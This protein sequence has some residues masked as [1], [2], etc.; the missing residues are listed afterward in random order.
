MWQEHVAILVTAPQCRPAGLRAIGRYHWL[1][2]PGVCEQRQRKTLP[3][4]L[5]GTLIRMLEAKRT[6]SVPWTEIRPFTF[7]FETQLR[8]NTTQQAM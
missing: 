3:W 5:L 2:V 6:N 7:F 4:P 1:S 8:T